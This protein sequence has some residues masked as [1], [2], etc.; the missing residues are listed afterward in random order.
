MSDTDPD[1]WNEPIEWHNAYQAGVTEFHPGPEAR[2]VHHMF[3]L[4]A[5]DIADPS[6]LRRVAKA[7]EDYGIRLEKSVFQCDLPEEQSRTSGA[8]SST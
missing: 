2:E 5:Y 8:P 7:C 4:V 6:R 1:D 3:Y